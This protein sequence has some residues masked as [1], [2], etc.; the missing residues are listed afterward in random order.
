MHTAQGVD[1]SASPRESG[2]AA[3]SPEPVPPAHTI[4]RAQTPAVTPA[5]ENAGRGSV[6]LAA[7][8][9]NASCAYLS[10]FPHQV[11]DRHRFTREFLRAQQIRQPFHA[12]I[13]PDHARRQYPS[14]LGV[15][16][17]NQML[18]IPVP[19]VMNQHRRLILTR[20]LCVPRLHGAGSKR[21]P[22]PLPSLDSPEALQ[23]ARRV[24]AVSRT[25]ADPLQAAE[26]PAAAV[27]AEECSDW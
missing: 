8:R 26:E 4:H 6:A 15:L 9:V 27:M 20:H 1:R 11:A 16:H 12:F 3:H 13:I 22:S 17:F 14:G 5:S 19:V 10:S 7:I 2:S 23:A 25:P 24:A 18:L 21:S